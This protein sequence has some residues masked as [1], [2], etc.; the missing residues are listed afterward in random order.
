MNL[1]TNLDTTLVLLQISVHRRKLRCK[2]PREE[3]Q[4]GSRSSPYYV[5]GRRA[6]RRRGSPPTRSRMI[7]ETRRSTST[8]RSAPTIRISRRPIQ[9]NLTLPLISFISPRTRVHCP[10]RG[11]EGVEGVQSSQKGVSTQL[12]AHQGPVQNLL[13]KSRAHNKQKPQKSLASKA[14]L[15]WFDIVQ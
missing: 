8:E 1:D 2:C 15:C 13:G 7:P 6:F 14:L 10:R 4:I 9:R 3:F 11:R 5:R 12:S